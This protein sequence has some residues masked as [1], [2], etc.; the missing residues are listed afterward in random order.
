MGPGEEPPPTE[1]SEPINMAFEAAD[2]EKTL[3][4]LGMKT[5]IVVDGVRS[6]WEKT[7]SESTD[8]KKPSRYLTILDSDES[9]GLTIYIGLFIKNSK[10]IFFTFVRQGQLTPD[11]D[12]L[13]NVE[14]AEILVVRLANY[15]KYKFIE[16]G[17]VSRQTLFGPNNPGQIQAP[18]PGDADEN[19]PSP[20]A[21]SPK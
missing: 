16:R 17:V 20:V 7:F 3:R 10:D 11:Y 4:S 6:D 14:S 15:I 12:T 9:R 8:S 5:L 2:L 21:G 19:L 1:E 13:K 18:G